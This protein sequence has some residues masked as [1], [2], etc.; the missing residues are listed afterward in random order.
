[1]SLSTSVV[2]TGVHNFVVKSEE[3]IGTLL[4]KYDGTRAETRFRLS[5]KQ[6]S[7]FKPAVDVSSVDYWQPRC[8]HQR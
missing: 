4:L 3:V 1:M 6:T 7:P 5:M 8:V 2:I